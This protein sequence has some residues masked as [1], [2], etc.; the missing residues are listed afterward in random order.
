GGTAEMA[1]LARGAVTPVVAPD[2]QGGYRVEY[3][4]PM[5]PS[6]PVSVEGDRLRLEFDGFRAVMSMPALL[7]RCVLTDSVFEPDTGRVVVRFLPDPDL[8]P[9]NLVP[10][11]SAD[12]AG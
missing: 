11:G 5:R 8:W 7:S 6:A 4:A 1:A 9:P 2:G 12:R 3:P 10:S